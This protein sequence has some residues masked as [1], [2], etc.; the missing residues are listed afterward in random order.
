[1]TVWLSG[2]ARAVPWFADADRRLTFAYAM[3][4][5]VP[6]LIGPSAAA[7]LQRLYEIV[8]R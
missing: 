7:M 3:N 4:K 8:N 6:C 1:M 5:M 2:R